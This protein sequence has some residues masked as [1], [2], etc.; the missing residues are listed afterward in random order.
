MASVDDNGESGPEPDGDLRHFGETVKAFRKRAGLT[1]EQLHPLIR[2]SVQ[3]IGS[4]EQGRRHP[5][6]KFVEKAEEALDAFGVIRLAAKQ[7][8]RRRGLAS[9]FR[10]WAE[11]EDSAI[12]LNTYE[13]RAI[14]GLLQPEPYARA[15]FET[16]PPLPTAGDL[17]ARM[18]ARS[19][20]QKLLLRTPY[21][22][23]S[24]IVEQSLIE[25]R[26]GGKEVTRE[27]ID[28]L[29]ECSLLPNV[30]IQIMP[31]VQ[32]VHAGADGPFRLLE[33]WEH[34]WLGYSEGQQS[35]LVIT[36]P[37]DV[38]ILHRRYAKLRIQALNPADSAD[39]LMRMRGSL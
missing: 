2:Y 8:Q 9:W 11:H 36:D 22:M 3:Y 35:G 17:E 28:H 16:V 4:V 18:V 33:T 39:L 10:R 19:E 26:T 1:Q 21:I 31:L 24:F 30:D 12:A 25:R 38:S 20:R 32:P 27:L 5:S 29:L 37:K 14:P 6:T 34:E 23:F 15:L 7:L 13:C